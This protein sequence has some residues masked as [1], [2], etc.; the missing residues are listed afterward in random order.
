MF[1]IAYVPAAVILD[2][3]IL[4]R[5]SFCDHQNFANDAVFVCGALHHRAIVW[6]LQTSFVISQPPLLPWL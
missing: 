6:R 3:T 1:V 5:K 2:E 4:D